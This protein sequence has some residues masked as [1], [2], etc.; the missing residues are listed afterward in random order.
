MTSQ[1]RKQLQYMLPYFSRR[2]GNQTMK[3]G[4]F[5]EK[6]YTN[7]GGETSRRSF[8]KESKLS[9]SLDEQSEDL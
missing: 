8:S 4:Q 9:I 7:F 6:P 5:I 1:P 3:F 2:K